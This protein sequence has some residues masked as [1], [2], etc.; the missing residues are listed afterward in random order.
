MKCPKITF[1]DINRPLVE[2]I[3]KLFEQNPIIDV[4]S[5][6]P[7]KFDDHIQYECIKGDI[8]EF[9][10]Q[11]NTGFVSAANALGIL[12]GGVDAAINNMFP[13]VQENI[14][15]IINDNGYINIY[16]E[17]FIPIG[18]ATIVPICEP[19]QN[20]HNQY[21]I[22]APTMLNPCNVSKTNNCYHALYATLRVVKKFNEY[23]LK[24]NKPEIETII[25][26]GL[27]TGV[28]GI[29][30]IDAARQFWR[31]IADFVKYDIVKLNVPEKY[32]KMYKDISDKPDVFIKAPV[33]MIKLQPY[34]ES[35]VKFKPKN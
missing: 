20:I 7:I 15:T 33:G 19:E 3:H 18:S 21:L 28:G 26:P 13:L 34:W 9:S 23:Q 22:T 30:E 16:G 27:G 11:E 25:C 35:F 4:D 32:S 2:H 1:I 5:E 8:K 29:H 24:N 14:T 17:G 6:S 31:A 12:G 10:G